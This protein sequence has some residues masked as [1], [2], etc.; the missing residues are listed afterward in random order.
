M[1]NEQIDYRTSF[2][3]KC[4]FGVWRSSSAESIANSQLR[5]H[6][7]DPKLA[8]LSIWRFMYCMGFL[9]GL[10]FPPRSILVG[11]LATQNCECV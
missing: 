7:F 4:C 11:R 2:P 3:L 1:N 10:Q 9:Q 5:G 6:A 8:L